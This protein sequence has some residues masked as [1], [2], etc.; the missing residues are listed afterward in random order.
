MVLAN[1]CNL[2]ILFYLE[3]FFKTFKYKLNPFVQKNNVTHFCYPVPLPA[4]PFLFVS[5]QPL[6]AFSY[7]PYKA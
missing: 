2:R 1:K 3:L 7:C 4:F 6:Q 5:N